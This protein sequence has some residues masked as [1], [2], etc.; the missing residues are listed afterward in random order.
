[1]E[2]PFHDTWQILCTIDPVD[3]LAEWPVYLELIGVLMKVYLLVRMP[4]VEVGRYITGNDHHGDGVQRGV[5]HPGRGVGEAWPKMD[6]QYTWLARNAG[7]AVSGMGRNLFVTRGNKPDAA[8][9][10][11]VKKRDNSMAAQAK[12]DFDAKPF[13]IVR[14]QIGS[15]ALP[16]WALSRCVL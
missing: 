16:G 14:K 3:S 11:R 1:V 10:K 15:D 12:D 5:C 13:Q 9:A 7:V 8:F 2:C 6:Q 4:A